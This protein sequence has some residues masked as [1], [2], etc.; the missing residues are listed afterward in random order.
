MTAN[1]SHVAGLVS[2]TVLLLEGGFVL[3]IDHDQSKIR[4]W[5]EKC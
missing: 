2:D 4:K 1:D 3:L 5:K